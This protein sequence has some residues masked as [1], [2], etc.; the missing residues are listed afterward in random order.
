MENITKGTD[1][2]GGHD[3]ETLCSTYLRYTALSKC[4]FGQDE[5]Y[6]NINELP[7]DNDFYKEAR[8]MAKSLGIDWKKMSHEDS[9][10][11]MLAMLEDTYNAMAAVGDKKHL[12]VEV[13]L[14]VIKNPT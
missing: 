12:T 11:I 13:K 5:N 1:E 2:L 4:L 6:Y 10:R 9:N 8:A 14:K 3:M 7:K